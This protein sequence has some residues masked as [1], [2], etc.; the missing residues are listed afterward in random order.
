MTL[1][2]EAGLS[3]AESHGGSSDGAGRPHGTVRVLAAVIRRDGRWLVCRR[4]AHKRHGGL[5]EFPGGKLEPGESLFESATREL[6]E[7]LA[8]R[9]LGVGDQVFVRRDAGSEFVIEFVAVEIEGEPQAIEHDELRWATAA[10]LA[11]LPLAPS[12]AE[13]A[14]TLPV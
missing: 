12:D 14:T 13:F 6:H 11:A 5:W 10:E 9:V 1:E 7:E 2:R 3:N 4:P 8:V